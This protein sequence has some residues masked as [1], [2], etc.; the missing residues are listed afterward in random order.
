MSATNFP[1][2]TCGFTFLGSDTEQLLAESK[3]Q[4]VCVKA[5]IHCC[6]CLIQSPYQPAL[7]TVLS[8]K[9]L[10]YGRWTWYFHMLLPFPLSSNFSP[11]WA[12]D[13]TNTCKVLFAIQLGVCMYWGFHSQSSHFTSWSHLVLKPDVQGNYLKKDYSSESFP[14]RLKEAVTSSYIKWHMVILNT[15]WISNELNQIC[16]GAKN[17][18]FYLYRSTVFSQSFYNKI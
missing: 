1:F 7:P 4:A 17:T 10:L 3:P 13:L 8:S 15:F 18:N 9:T 5:V 16:S 12:C 14:L 6:S 11:V 2:S